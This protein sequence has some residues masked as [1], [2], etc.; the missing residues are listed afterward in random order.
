MI[1]HLEGKTFFLFTSYKSLNQARELIA[2]ELNLPILV[3]GDEPK[4]VL[5]K[6]FKQLGNAILLAT[7][8]FW[9][10]VDVKG[11]ALSCVIIDKIP[12]ASPTSPI[13][14]AKIAYLNQKNRS[15][16]D[17]YQLPHAIIALKQGV[18][19]LIRDDNDKGVLMLADPRLYARAYGKRFFLSLPQMN[20]TRNLSTVIEFIDELENEVISH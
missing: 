13:V 1:K 10:G 3:Q 12:F 16:F 14:K 2:Q 9:E 8:S 15:A 19:R 4:H 7:S 17:D 18:G 6:R 20:R 5:L 11:S